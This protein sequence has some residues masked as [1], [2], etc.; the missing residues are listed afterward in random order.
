M[1][2]KIPLYYSDAVRHGLGLRLD[3]AWVHRASSADY[4]TWT[5]TITLTKGPVECGEHTVIISRQ[6]NCVNEFRRVQ[7]PA[8]PLLV[9]YKVSFILEV[10]WIKVLF[11]FFLQDIFWLKDSSTSRTLRLKS[12]RE[13]GK[14]TILSIAQVSNTGFLSLRE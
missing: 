8:L 10:R 14:S 3:N 6:V 2:N 1:I 11:S 13:P 7:G 12:R 9:E 5:N 4:C